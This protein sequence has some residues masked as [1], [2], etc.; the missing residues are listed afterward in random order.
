MKKLSIISFSALLLL[1]SA[2]QAEPQKTQTQTSQAENSAKLL[3][4][5]TCLKGT[6]P[7]V[8]DKARLKQMLIRSGKITTQ[9]SST[10]ANKIINDYIKKKQDAFKHCQKK[11]K[12]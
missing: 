10:E 3:L 5:K 1:L 9:M 2:C 12:K 11:E 8:Q 4:K 7:Q 6:S